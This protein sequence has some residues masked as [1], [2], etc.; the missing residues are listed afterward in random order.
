MVSIVRVTLGGPGGGRMVAHPEP[1]RSAPPTRNRQA[2]TRCMGS[3]IAACESA[4]INKVGAERLSLY[5]GVRAERQTDER[6]ERRR[7]LCH[8]TPRFAG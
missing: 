3:T 6:L 2:N 5:L 7:L 4:D 1:R 8:S